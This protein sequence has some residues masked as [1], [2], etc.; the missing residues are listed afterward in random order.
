MVF[1]LGVAGDWKNKFT[2]AQSEAFDKLYREK[3]EGSG[4]HMEFEIPELET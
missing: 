1:F 2:V 3:M 4:L